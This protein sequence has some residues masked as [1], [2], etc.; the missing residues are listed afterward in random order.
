MWKKQE[1]ILS[2]YDRSYVRAVVRLLTIFRTETFPEEEFWDQALIQWIPYKLVF[3][4]ICEFQ[5]CI[6]C[7][8]EGNLFDLEYLS[9][10]NIQVSLNILSYITKDNNISNIQQRFRR[11][12]LWL[13]RA[14][15]PP[16][17]RLHVVSISAMSPR[18]YMHP[19]ES[20]KLVATD[21]WGTTK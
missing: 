14:L 21:L 5:S 16:P 4:S 15:N 19:L 13:V 3:M 2:V 8:W 17:F 1:I 9:A 11:R 6:N 20:P 18:A 12:N 7:F 10:K